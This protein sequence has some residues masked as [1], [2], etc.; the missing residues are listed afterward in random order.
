MRAILILFFVINFQKVDTIK[1]VE[2]FDLDTQTEFCQG[3]DI[4]YCA[5]WKYVKGRYSRCPWIPRCPR[6]KIFETAY[7]NGYNRGFSKGKYDAI[8][9][10]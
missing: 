3:W 7:E 8:E 1:P 10:R 2:D 6:P 4:G 9:S 5:G